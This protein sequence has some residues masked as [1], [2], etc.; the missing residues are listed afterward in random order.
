MNA[1]P[2]ARSFVLAAGIFAASACYADTVRLIASVRI[3]PGAAITLAD[4]ADLDGEEAESLAKIVV[5]R[6]EEGAF[7]LGVERLRQQLVVAGANMRKLEL[8]GE[9]SVVR[10]LREAAASGAPAANTHLSAGPLAGSQP[11]SQPGMR[12]IDPSAHAGSTTP[13]GLVCEI[14]RNAFGP[15]A[16]DLRLELSSEHLDRLTPIAG[17][18]YEIVKKSAL[19]AARVEF[20]I[21]AR[22]TQGTE[23]RSRVRV[24]PRF[25]RS[26][27][28]THQEVRRGT[29]V[30]GDSTS[31]ETRLL[32]M[33]EAT[34]AVDPAAVGTSTFLH[35]LPANSIVTRSDLSRAQEVRRRD[36]VTVRREVGMVAI[37][38][39]AV[40]LED[41]AIGDIIALQKAGTRRSRDARAISAEI[42][43]PGRAVIR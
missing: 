5:G 31:V 12:V 29:A 33:N 17:V 14:V 3:A 32:S 27:L 41:G 28:V 23:T 7:E 39:E 34:D 38:F 42:V 30:S 35:A 25:E 10:P 1:L 11:G 6:G 4:V 19:R 9:K 24:L 36:T 18:R 13:L 20:E 26:A 2:T 22:P 37:E 15:E 40:A 8:V 43:A 16:C 21:V